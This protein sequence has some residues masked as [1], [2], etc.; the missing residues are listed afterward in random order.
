MRETFINVVS[1]ERKLKVSQLTL[2]TLM[3][4]LITSTATI[5]LPVESNVNSIRVALASPR[6]GAY[7]KYTVPEF[8][9]RLSRPALEMQLTIS[10]EDCSQRQID[11]CVVSE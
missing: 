5:A 10:E 1:N 11:V 7:T 6:L 8:M 4:V 2:V 9:V 3:I